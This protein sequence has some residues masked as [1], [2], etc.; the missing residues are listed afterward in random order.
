MFVIKKK[1]FEEYIGETCNGNYHLSNLINDKTL[2]FA[3][4]LLANNFINKVIPE[5]RRKTYTIQGLTESRRS[6]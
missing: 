6:N 2:L 4:E 5:S 1:A 3:N